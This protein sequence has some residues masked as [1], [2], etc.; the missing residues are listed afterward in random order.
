MTVHWIDERSSV[1][2]ITP[3]GTGEVI[4]IVGGAVSR[5]TSREVTDPS[6][7]ASAANVW[8]GSS[9]LSST[10]QS[11]SPAPGGIANV[12]P[13]GIDTNAPGDVPLR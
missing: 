8:H 5:K 9:D 6:G 13:F 3:C 1:S 2:K 11:P 10:V 12:P 7:I 4:V